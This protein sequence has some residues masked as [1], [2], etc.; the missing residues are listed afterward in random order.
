MRTIRAMPLPLAILLAMLFLPVPGLEA[1][2]PTGGQV[3]N[4]QELRAMEKTLSASG[5][6]VYEFEEKANAPARDRR[7]E[8][9][10]NRNAIKADVAAFTRVTRGK[11][12]PRLS[13]HY[14][15]GIPYA[16]LWDA[17]PELPALQCAYL[18]LDLPF[19]PNGADLKPLRGVPCLKR[20]YT[21]Y[22][23]LNMLPELPQVTELILKS[24][25]DYIAFAPQTLAER[26][27]NLL[28]LTLPADFPCLDFAAM[29]LPPSLEE[30][31]ILPEAPLWPEDT[32]KEQYSD[33]LAA[34][35]LNTAKQNPAIRF[36]NGIPASKCEPLAKLTPAQRGQYATLQG[37]VW[38]E[39]EFR[40]HAPI[41]RE[42]KAKE[43]PLRGKIMVYHLGSYHGAEYE[44]DNQAL[45]AALTNAPNECDM[46]VIFERTFKK[47]RPSR[48]FHIGG[49]DYTIVGHLYIL[50]PKTNEMTL[51][52]FH[53]TQAHSA[54][55]DPWK[56]IEELF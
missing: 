14:D 23:N 7:L 9:H 50:D 53:H 56:K 52:W 48:Y 3:W 51:A 34:Y 30:V 29:A 33:V 20:L 22:D 27:P 39:A 25:P 15:G 17:I 12:I 26:F 6:Q 42:A 28:S 41:A 45:R 49:S 1:A 31:I 44:G 16:D 35:N 19:A 18:G 21:P 5:L 2:V 36:I 55:P 38:A 10:F 43:L 47:M 24:D 13:F 8:L 37:Y 32:G 40:K 11:S 4:M 54:V 46:L